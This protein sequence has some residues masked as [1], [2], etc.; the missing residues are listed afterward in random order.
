MSIKDTNDKMLWFN[1]II[2]AIGGTIG[3]IGGAI[4]NLAL[5]II[6]IS[7][8]WFGVGVNLMWIWIVQNI[9]KY[10]K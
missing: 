5:G 8:I 3:I 4:N 2:I 1:I 6:A 10:R 7:I 9:P